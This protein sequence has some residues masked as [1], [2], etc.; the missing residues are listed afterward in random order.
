MLQ[1]LL[2]SAVTHLG[3]GP[4]RLVSRKSWTGLAAVLV[5]LR[6]VRSSRLLHRVVSKI[7]IPFQLVQLL[8]LLFVVVVSAHLI[9]CVFGAY[10]TLIQEN[11]LDTWLATHGLCWPGP[12]PEGLNP[13]DREKNPLAPPPGA[14]R[15]F[16]CAAPF[17]IY[18]QAFYFAM[19]T[20]V[21][22]TDTVK[23]GPREPF[24]SDR[25]SIAEWRT[26]EQ[27]VVI[28]ML[29]IGA[30]AWAYITARF[31]DMV[32]NG[33]PATHEFYQKV[34]L[35][36]RFCLH[37]RIDS[38]KRRR[39]RE[40]M[41]EMREELRDADECDQ[42]FDLLSPHLL[43]DILWDVHGRWLIKMPFLRS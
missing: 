39:L 36:N 8:G 43:Q 24:F 26:E 33:D 1:R 37:F 21:A 35:L 29:F 4:T 11:V 20:I 15:L 2:D 5:P 30:C 18:L 22:Y 42:V 19:G 6:L 40:Y 14:Q 17:T 9:A 41:H 10:A 38:R 25:D 12:G 31:V 28:A 23:E 13:A 34:D 32:S 7:A 3:P 16:Q 27:W